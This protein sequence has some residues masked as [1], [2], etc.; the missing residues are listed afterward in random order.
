MSSRIK[1]IFVCSIV[2]IMLI[3]TCATVYAATLM[4]PNPCSGVVANSCTSHPKVAGLTH[5][6][7]T[8]RNSSST[9]TVDSFN[10]DFNNYGQYA[11]PYTQNNDIGPGR[12]VTFYCNFTY[13]P[14]YAPWMNIWNEVTK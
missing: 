12:S 4:S 13:D 9:G 3:S 8:P 1:K 10:Y 2:C 6:H 5:Y 7:F 14:N 11:G